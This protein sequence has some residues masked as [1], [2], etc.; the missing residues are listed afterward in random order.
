MARRVVGLTPG[1]AR[2]RGAS[3]RRLTE[4]VGMLI[5]Q[6]ITIVGSTTNLV[7][8][9][10]QADLS[11]LTPCTLIRVRGALQ[12]THQSRTVGHDPNGAFS[13]SIVKENARAIGITAIP[14]PVS[15]LGDDTFLLWEPWA[16]AMRSANEG[17]PLHQRIPIDGKAMRKIEDGDGL[18]VVC[19][20]GAPGGQNAQLMYALR[21]LFLLH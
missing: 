9:L 10:T 2:V 19:Q 3:T 4:W 20:N 11:V 21:F 5:T 1:P 17:Q 16:L 8:E 18:V 6:P 12:F 13:I 14:S 15:D 7:G